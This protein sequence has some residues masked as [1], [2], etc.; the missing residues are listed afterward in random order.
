MVGLARG[1]V[2]PGV[3]GQGIPAMGVQLRRQ[4]V[5]RLAGH[6]VD[7]A[8]LIAVALQKSQRLAQRIE[9]RLDGEEE[10]LAVEAGDE[11]GRVGDAQ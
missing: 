5:H 4:C 8:R 9:A 1:R 6:A 3:V 10:V 11:D 7:D 2:Q